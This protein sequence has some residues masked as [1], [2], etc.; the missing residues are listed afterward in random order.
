MK[1]SLS[2][3]AAT[4]REK[5]GSAYQVLLDSA[6]LAD[7][8]G[9]EAVWLPERHF[10]EFGAPYPNPSVV[11]AAVAA[12]TRRIGVRAGS[13]VLPLH[14][15]AR[16]AEEW[17]VVDQ[18]SGGR[19]G[20]SF[21]SG[22]HAQD[23]VLSRFDMND[24]RRVMAEGID[25]VRALWRGEWRPFTDASGQEFEVRTMPQPVQPELPTW[26]TTGGSPET[27]ELAGTLGAGVLTHL[28][29][30]AP[31]DL[32]RNIANY[33][34]TWTG[35]GR[36]HITLMLHT[37]ILDGSKAS[38]ERA[39][40]ELAR[41]LGV[42]MDLIQANAADAQ[43]SATLRSMSEADREAVV[44]QGVARFGQLG[45]VC[46]AHELPERLATVSSWDVDEVACLIDF[47]FDHESIMRSL[48][49]LLTT[50]A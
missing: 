50:L 21:A 12:I 17:A 10:A 40:V 38:A 32:A 49:D 5:A 3:F 8:A 44:R 34:K 41:Y 46:T 24:R 48:D 33:R 26:I 15:P 47:G 25:A 30:Q 23:F 20:I 27:F 31:G 18:L 6:R 43:G 42:S 2:Y 22:W 7:E 36:G 13:V 35:P 14:H 1:I 29:G 16:V 28:L 37:H 4:E 9:L 11:G 19:A 45:L 39:R